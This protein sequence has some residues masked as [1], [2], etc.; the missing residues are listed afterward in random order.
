M[1]EAVFT[2][3]DCPGPRLEPSRPADL[4]ARMASDDFRRLLVTH[5][6]A[7][8]DSLLNHASSATRDKGQRDRGLS[9]G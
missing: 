6:V 3:G 2:E 5:D 7:V 8:L 4:V 1:S 9:A